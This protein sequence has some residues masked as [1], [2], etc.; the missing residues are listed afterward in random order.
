M[1][2]CSFVFNQVPCTLVTGCLIHAGFDAAYN[3][4]NPIML[5]A[6]QSART[7]NPSYAL[8]LTG[9]SLGAAVAT[10]AGAYLRVEGYACD[11]YTYGS[12]RVGNVV[13]AN[14]VTQQTGANYR[15]THLDDPVPRLPPILLNY[16]H[17]SPEFWLSDGNATTVNYGVQDI[18]VCIGN[19]RRSTPFPSVPCTVPTF[20]ALKLTRMADECVMQCGHNSL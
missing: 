12:P 5:A 14:Y 2:H 15:V 10:L 1:P 8:V 20:V 17:T 3:E 4:I 6:V 18:K 7:A 19:V 11:V 16:A 13:F 9:H